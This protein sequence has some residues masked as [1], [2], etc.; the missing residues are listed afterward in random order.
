MSDLEYHPIAN[1]FPLIEDQEFADFVEDIRTRG[2]ADPIVLLDGAILDGRNRYRALQE[3][4]PGLTPP[5]EPS[6]FIEFDG[7]DP[8]AFVIS[9]N[10][11]RRHLNIPQ[12]A[13]VAA[14]MATLPPWRPSNKAANLPGSIPQDVAAKTLSI[15]ERAVRM[16]KRVHEAGVD[17]LRAALTRGIIATD[18]AAQLAEL[19]TDEQRRI[20]TAQSPNL[21]RH[22][23]TAVK[24]YH[25]AERER[26]LGERQME[27]PDG[28][29]GVILE[30]F[31]WD[32]ATYSEAGK[33]SRHASNH[34]PTA[35]QAHSPQEIV[36]RT[37]DRFAKADKDCVLF[38]WT[39]GPHLAIALQVMALR[40][41][42]YRCQFI[43]LKNRMITGYW[44][45]GMHEILLVGTRGKPP[46]PA[47]GKQFR[48]VLEG[49]VREHSHKPDWQYTLIESYFPTLPKLE[50]NP[51]DDEERPGWTR[52]GKPH[53]SAQAKTEISPT[54][55]P[56]IT[57]IA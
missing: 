48:S 43:W 16:A 29:F 28:I 20:V 1:I 49:E 24:Q 10:L 12:R 42:D 36:E 17:E 27:A 39:T 41:F 14:K 56:L 33:D 15:S 11:K 3:L 37:A 18:T 50:L 46:A 40:N 35:A 22:A 9:K 52:W 23:R 6:F 30:D 38:M 31:E 4:R 13:D 8:L 47:P 25:R 26:M 57:G 32:F 19:P 51:G 2:L 44:Q 34:Y 5:D 54:S 53:R 21:S 55:S 7:T 45:R